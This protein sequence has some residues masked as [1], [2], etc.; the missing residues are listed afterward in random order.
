MANTSKGKNVTEKNL[1]NKYRVFFI[2]CAPQ[3]PDPGIVKEMDK[4]MTIID[5]IWSL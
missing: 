4:I 1:F 5:D 2:P 3:I